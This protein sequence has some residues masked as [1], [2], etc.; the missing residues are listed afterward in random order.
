M[1]CDF[2]NTQGESIL[3]RPRDEFVW[4]QLYLISHIPVFLLL[5]K[6]MDLSVSIT[7][8]TIIGLRSKMI[9]LKDLKPENKIK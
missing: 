8:I 9:N 2:C 4:L 6:Y 5:I 1:L 7:S 3:S